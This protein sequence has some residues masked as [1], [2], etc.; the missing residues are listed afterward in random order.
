MAANRSERSIETLIATFEGI[1][2][3]QLR[4]DLIPLLGISEHCVPFDD[5]L[6]GHLTL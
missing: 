2:A 6:R 4:E 1:V 5:R 3:T